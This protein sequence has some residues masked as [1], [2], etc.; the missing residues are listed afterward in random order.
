M[1][2]PEELTQPGDGEIMSWLTSFTIEDL[3]MLLA[4]LFFSLILFLIGRY[5][6]LLLVRMVRSNLVKRKLDQLTIDFISK[7]IYIVGLIVVA[8]IA[9]TN[10]GIPMTPLVALMGAA[11]IAVGLALQDSLANLASGLLIIL[12]HP[13]KEADSIEIGEDRLT[14]TVDSVHFFHTILRTVD[15]S[16]LLVPNSE[17][18]G[19]PILNFTDLGWRRIDLTFSI[20]YDDDLR[21]AKQILEEIAAADPRIMA[22]PATVIAVQSLGE[23]GVDLVFQPHVLPADY[24]NV[25]YALN[26]QVKVRFDEASIALAAPQRVVRLIPEREKKA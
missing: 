8:I 26:E 20:G 1:P 19:N 3:P 23:N 15:N 21:R 4:R 5:L 7:A 22:E 25:K 2:T 18:M 9:L 12:L 13:Y 11:A 24:A 14:G 6:V 17:V 16:R 10:L